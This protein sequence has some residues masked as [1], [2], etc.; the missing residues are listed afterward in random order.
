MADSLTSSV[1]A[2]ISGD[3]SN[4]AGTGETAAV[5]FALSLSASLTDGTAASKADKVWFAQDRTLTGT[6]PED[7]DMYDLASF[8]IGSGAGQDPFGNAYT[9][10]EMVALLIRNDSTS[11]GNIF[12]GAKNTTAAFN[13]F[14]AVGTTAD[15]TAA[16]GPIKPGGFFL[17]H[18]PTDPAYAIADS[19]NHLLT[20]TPTANA[21]YDVYIL[22]RS[23]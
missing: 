22:F 17:I 20:I 18:A 3:F 10:V 8:D 11:T 9:N 23:A 7:I 21:T 15:D 13:S 19:S 16:I 4:T 5:A 2:S 6:T 1:K 12:V 14:I